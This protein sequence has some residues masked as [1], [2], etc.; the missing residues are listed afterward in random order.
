VRFDKVEG[1]RFT[2]IN[3]FYAGGSE[4]VA[5]DIP[6]KICHPDTLDPMVLGV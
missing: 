4:M 5:P 2:K 3:F 1:V 6:I